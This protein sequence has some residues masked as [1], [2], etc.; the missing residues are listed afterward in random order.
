[1]LDGGGAATL[2]IAAST[3]LTA[4]EA[5]DMSVGSGAATLDIAPR[6]R[7]V[8]E[9]ILAHDMPDAPMSVSTL[10]DDVEGPCFWTFS[11]LHPAL[12]FVRYMHDLHMVQQSRILELENRSY[13]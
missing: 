13:M 11:W 7:F 6:T 8:A 1:M 5:Q 4:E 2:D 3:R 9:N 12:Y 10:R